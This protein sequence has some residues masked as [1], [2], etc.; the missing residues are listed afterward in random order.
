MKPQA[1]L[2]RLA[3]TLA[4]VAIAAVIGWNLWVYYMDAPWTRDGRVRAD[5]VQVAPDVSGLVAQVFIHDNETVHAGQIL[6]TIDTARYRLALNLAQ[7]KLAAAQ[8]VSAQAERDA[9]RYA[10]VSQ[11]AVS[12]QTRQ[13]S[14][15]AAAEA[16]AA[17]AEAQADCDTAT[18]NLARTTVRAP[19]SGQIANSGL[20]PG[21]YVTTGQGVA[22]L[23]ATDAF[24]VDGYFEETKLPRIALGDPAR[25][26]LMGGGPVITGHVA[27]IAAGIADNERRANP[28]L[29]ADVNPT[30][31]WV[32]LAARVPVRIALDHVP[33]GVT[34]V[35]GLTAT[36]SIQPPH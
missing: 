31:T 14:E 30:F 12:Q 26:Q 15:A 17:E 5:V 33:A 7:A 34:L 20:E 27:G 29:L 21:D 3:V 35:S 18:L 10:N 24:Y 2:L 19:V 28:T 9:A 16:A 11:D 25:V 22:A 4:V 32:R 36:V 1:L 13:Q 6:F 23:V 8:A